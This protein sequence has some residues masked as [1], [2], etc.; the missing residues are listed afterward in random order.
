M[1]SSSSC[2]ILNDTEHDV[3]ITHEVNWE[4]AVG[5]TRGVVNALVLGARVLALVASDERQGE[6]RFHNVGTREI[7][8]RRNAGLTREGW[9]RVASVLERGDMALAEFLCVSRR[10]AEEMRST[11]QAFQ[12]KAELIRPGEKYTWSG[13]LSLTM[14]VHVMNDKFQFDDRGCFTG[15]TTGSDKLYTISTHFKKLDVC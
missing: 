4:V 11:I 1:G 6:R 8:Q 12:E 14:R 3:W 2:S 10:E 13:T 7:T 9:V 15:P 5:V